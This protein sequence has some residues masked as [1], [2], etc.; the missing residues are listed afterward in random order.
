MTTQ[1]KKSFLS[2]WS[3]FLRLRLNQP[4]KI[5]NKSGLWEKLR[6]GSVAIMIFLRCKNS[7]RT[8]LKMSQ[9]MPVPGWKSLAGRLGDYWFDLADF[10]G[11]RRKT[12]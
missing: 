1:K 9:L 2:G 10:A 8:G 7:F 11:F 4:A 12:I 5:L 6:M 3:V